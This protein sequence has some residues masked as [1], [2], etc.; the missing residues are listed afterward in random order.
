VT[1]L[2]LATVVLASSAAF[3]A[4]RTTMGLSAPRKAAAPID[5]TEKNRIYFAKQDA[6]LKKSNPAAYAQLLKDREYNSRGA[7]TPAQNM[8]IRAS[9]LWWSGAMSASAAV[10]PVG[11]KMAMDAFLGANLYRLPF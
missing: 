3:A 7:N 8:M 10:N 6:K 5:Y 1:K 4:P 2:I 11:T 9:G